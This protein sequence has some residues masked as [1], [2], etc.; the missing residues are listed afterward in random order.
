MRLCDNNDTIRLN[1]TGAPTTPLQVSVAYDDITATAVT[2]AVQTTSVSGAGATAILSA[3]SSN[4]T[5]QVSKLQAYNP[6]TT[7]STV[8]IEY[9]DGGTAWNIWKGVVPSLST[10]VYSKNGTNWSIL[11][12]GES[13]NS[14]ES[15]IL[16]SGFVTVPGI[17]GANSTRTLTSNVPVAIYMGKAQAYHTSISAVWNCTSGAVGV[18]WAEIAIGVGEPPFG[19]MGPIRIAGW[20]D[21]SATI[22]GTATNTTAITVSDVVPG[23]NLWLMIGGVW[24]T[25]AP[26]F[27]AYVSSTDQVYSGFFLTYSSGLLGEPRFSLSDKYSQSWVASVAGTDRYHAI[28]LL[29]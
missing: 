7:D 9:Y 28:A 27:R 3:P 23:D 25:T 10:L 21:I 16:K 15:H 11:R 24:V 5:R 20:A 13:L 4:T 22:T 14:K 6:N 26:T 12:Y 18:T 8:V 17:G 29:L 19:N 1:H 2:P